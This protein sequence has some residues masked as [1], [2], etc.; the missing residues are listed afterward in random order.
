M[1]SDEYILNLVDETIAFRF[2][3]V[4]PGPPGPVA[5]RTGGVLISPTSGAS[6]SDGDSKAYFRVTEE[7]A[8]LTLQDVAASCSTP[9]TAGATTIQIRRVRGG[10]PVDMLTTPITI[11]ANET[12]SDTA[13]TPAV[14]DTN[15]NDIQEGDQIHIDLDSVSSG[16]LGVFVSFTFNT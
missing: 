3:G 16:T 8:G 14:I 4:L 11:D 13:A 2:D 10:T 12:D 9:G 15:N 5:G 1:P 6:P 7:M